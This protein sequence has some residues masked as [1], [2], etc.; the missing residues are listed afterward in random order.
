MDNMMGEVSAGVEERDG[1]LRYD[2][3]F[4]I[5]FEPVRGS[6][7]FYQV[8]ANPV[9]TV[10]DQMIEI[11]PFGTWVLHPQWDAPLDVA[12][13][14]LEDRWIVELGIPLSAMGVESGDDPKWGFNF[15][16][17][18]RRLDA[19]SAFQPPI[20]FDSDRMAILRLE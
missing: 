5:L 1:H 12:A 3:N 18:H 20:R 8:Y 4:S 9:G 2:D 10:F 17:W 19:T 15:M 13:E 6:Q 14:M 16:R 11:C 7:V